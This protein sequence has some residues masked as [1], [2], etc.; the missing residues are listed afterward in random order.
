MD[1][2]FFPSRAPFMFLNLNPIK[3]TINHLPLFVLM[4]T[5]DFSGPSYR[6][7]IYMREMHTSS[8]SISSMV[9]C[10]RLSLY[11]FKMKIIQS[12]YQNNVPFTS[13]QVAGFL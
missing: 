9:G 10:S 3:F 6:D 13:K 5:R 8:S 1:F 4:E 2:G 12:K 7:M 11:Y